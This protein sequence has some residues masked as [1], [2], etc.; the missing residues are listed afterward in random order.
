MEPKGRVICLV[1]YMGS[2]KSSVGKKLAD[3]LGY[4]FEDT[5][6]LIVAKDGR[7]IPDIF[8]QEGEPFFRELEHALLKSLVT[9]KDSGMVLATGGGIVMDV[10]NRPLLKELGTVVYLRADAKALYDRVRGD[11]GRP[12]L[13]VEDR[14]K[15]MR[16]MLT[17]RGPVYEECADIIID[18]DG[19]TPDETVDAVLGRLGM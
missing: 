17:V 15:T 10:R 19:L 9:R 2:G 16:D 5:D 14:L 12:L 13:N 11:E 18:T 8:R 3:R 4:A 1:G 7:S 6:E